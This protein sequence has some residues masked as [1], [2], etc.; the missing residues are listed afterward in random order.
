MP[1]GTEVDL[2]SGGIVLDGDPAPPR[3]PAQQPPIFVAFCS[4]T[5][6]HLSNC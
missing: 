2:G 5:V 4:G 3:K 6:V 1:L